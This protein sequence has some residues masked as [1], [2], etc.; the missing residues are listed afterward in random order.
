MGDITKL[1][2]ESEKN[3]SRFLDGSSVCFEKAVFEFMT[4]V[5]EG[6]LFQGTIELIG[7]HRFPDIVA[8]K[9]FGVEV[10]ATIQNHWTTLGNSVLESTRVD[11]VEHIYLMF[12][13]FGKPIEFKYRKYEECLLDVAITHSP[14]YLIDMQLPDGESIFAKM[15][16]SYDQI[17]KTKNPIASFIDYYKRTC[18][19]NGVWW[20]EGK[21]EERSIPLEIRPWSDLKTKE[22][23]I[24]IAKA[25]LLFPEVFSPSNPS[26]YDKVAAW[27][28]RDYGVVSSSLRDS[29]TA[30]GQV[31]IELENTQYNKIPKVFGRL[32]DNSDLLIS[33]LKNLTDEEIEKYWCASNLTN[34]TMRLEHWLNLLDKCANDHLK[35]T[36]MPIACVR[37][38][39]EKKLENAKNS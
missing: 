30:G 27:L 5:A 13:K 6:T 7:G 38:Y 17:R 1:E 34:I 36:N 31:C 24:L 25:M 11:T 37:K 10:K 9:N 23:K 4:Y 35:T 18:N 32:L 39:M 28:V 21:G 16:T 3:P 33:L 2:E 12:G 8:K 26:K 29:F 20:L 22:K 14:R 19:P 15:G